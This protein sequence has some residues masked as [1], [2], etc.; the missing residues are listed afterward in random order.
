MLC[1]ILSHAAYVKSMSCNYITGVGVGEESN[2]IEESQRNSANKSKKNQQV[3]E[4]K[5]NHE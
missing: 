4:S 1:L 3:I 5:M 2:F